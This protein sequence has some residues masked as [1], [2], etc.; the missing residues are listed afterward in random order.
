MSRAES[1]S[2]FFLVTAALFHADAEAMVFGSR[3]L[4]SK[5]ADADKSFKFSEAISLGPKWL[6]M[7]P[8]LNQGFTQL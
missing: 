8:T 6:W 5:Q 4:M 3:L 7:D 1:K 2:Y